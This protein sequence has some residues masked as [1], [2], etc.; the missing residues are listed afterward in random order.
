MVKKFFKF[1][2]VTIVVFLITFACF[3]AY[4][5]F[6]KND[7]IDENITNSDEISNEKTSAEPIFKLENYPKVDASTATQ[8]LVNAFIAD[9]TG[10]EN[11]SEDYFDYSTTHPAYLKL[12]EGK[13]DLIVVTEPS[14][15]E[16]KYAEENNVELEVVPVVREGFVFYVNSDNPVSNLSLEQVQDIYTGKIKN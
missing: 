3:M 15:E 13:V 6:T 5:Y 14:E 7:V 11:I 16:L 1:L 12:I 8:P 10:E 9:F 2:I 4:E